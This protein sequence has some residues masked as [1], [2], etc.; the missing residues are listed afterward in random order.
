[1]LMGNSTVANRHGSRLWGL[2]CTT[3]VDS[4]SGGAA[5]DNRGPCCS[6]LKGDPAICDRILSRLV[7]MNV[8]ICVL[9]LT[10]DEEPMF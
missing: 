8:C 5:R 9:K 6:S 3:I 1:M 7:T 2:I 10:V 4:A